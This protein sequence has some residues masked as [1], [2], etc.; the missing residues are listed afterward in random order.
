MG[1]RAVQILFA[2]L[3]AVAVPAASRATEA[4][5]LFG[6][7]LSVDGITFSPRAFSVSWGGY[8]AMG[9]GE[10][11]SVSRGPDSSEPATLVA[12][13]GDELVVL[14]RNHDE[15]NTTDMINQALVILLATA[16]L[17]LC[18]ALDGTRYR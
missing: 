4:R 5:V 14:R 9:T 16:K 17:L 3:C 15:R 6:T 18:S 11:T 10:K 8:S 1:F 13:F 7:G 12:A 2:T